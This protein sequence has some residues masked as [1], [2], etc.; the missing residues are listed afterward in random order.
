MA[1]TLNELAN[2]LKDKIIAMQAAS[3]SEEK[4]FA[5]KYNNLKLSMHPTKNP[6]PHVTIHLAMSEAEFSL[7]T[8]E[9]IDG[10]LGPDERYILKWLQRPTVIT[11]LRE[12]WASLAEAKESND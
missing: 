6:E 11:D 10:G 9:K 4:M 8:M 3:R 7:K 1:K 5:Q 2:N 12:T